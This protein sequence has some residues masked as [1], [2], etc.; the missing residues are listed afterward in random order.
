MIVNLVS[1]TENSPA[2]V[3][4]QKP[5][6]HQSV[7]R[8]SDA[9]APGHVLLPDVALKKGAPAPIMEE[10]EQPK[11]VAE[12]AREAISIPSVE[13]AAPD[14]ASDRKNILAER[15]WEGSVLARLETNKQFPKAASR[16]GVEGSALLRII[17]S[18]QG[19]LI[20]AEII[21]SAGNELLDREAVA[22][23]RRAEPY[24][25]PPSTVSGERI[26]LTVPVEFL[27]R[28]AEH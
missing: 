10:R 11:T 9:I 12:M 7:Q 3:M 14:S 23:A 28:N 13:S 15:Q 18:R 17:I 26:R 6:P 20:K 2:A 24:P 21:E 22:L 8:P 1:P 27:L 16:I 19:R 5:S 4:H 25:K